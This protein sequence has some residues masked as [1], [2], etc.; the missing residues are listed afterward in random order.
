MNIIGIDFS[1]NSI[2]ITIYDGE[3]KHFSIINR[4][5]FSKA[6]PEN[7][8]Y[9]SV[10]DYLKQ[11]LIGLNKHI[12][13]DRPPN[14]KD[15][16]AKDKISELNR[17]HS[18]HLVGCETITQAV[19]KIITP[20]ITEDTKVGI[21]HYI[22]SRN[23]GGDATIQII[24][25]TYRL[26]YEIKKHTDKIFVI[27][28]PT[29]KLFAGKGN[30]QKADMVRA[31]INDA[32]IKHPFKDNIKNAPNNLIKNPKEVLKPIDD[33]IDSYFVAKYVKEVIL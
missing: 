17:W 13:F 19:M 11:G 32:T 3:W 33:V 9:D 27:P 1:M 10:A 5:Q 29:I 22:T 2:G 20:Y 7:Y 4:Y 12:V 31:Y 18:S 24:E 23:S 30:F 25:A 26:K 16:K 28:A 8:D 15:K 6:K 14:T 21:E